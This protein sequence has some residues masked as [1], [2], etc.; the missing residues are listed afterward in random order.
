MCLTLC[1]Q[2]RILYDSDVQDA[3]LGCP[4]NEQRGECETCD[5]RAGDV[6][7]LTQSPLPKKGWCC[8]FNADLHTAPTIR[9]IRDEFWGEIAQRTPEDNF[10]IWETQ[11]EKNG[12]EYV[13]VVE[14][15]TLP[16][17]YGVPTTHWADSVLDEARE[18]DDFDFSEFGD[19]VPL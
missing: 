12:D 14:S 4:Y 19:S 5:H 17:T 8:H 2:H 9:V 15:L 6:C 11:Y 7:A 13:V 16:V 1:H 10:R 18:Q 3:C